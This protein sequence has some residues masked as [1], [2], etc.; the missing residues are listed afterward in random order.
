MFLEQ[1]PLFARAS[2]KFWQ[3]NP[4]VFTSGKHVSGKDC[5]VVLFQNEGLLSLRHI[6]LLFSIVRND[7]GPQDMVQFTLGPAGPLR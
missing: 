5:K 6:N 3:P 1:S 2:W 7:R 4:K